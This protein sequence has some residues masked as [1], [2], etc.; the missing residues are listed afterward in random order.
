MASLSDKAKIW[1]RLVSEGQ[2]CH[3]AT[4][5]LRAPIS[6]CRQPSRTIVRRASIRKPEMKTA[7]GVFIVE[8]AFAATQDCAGLRPGT[9]INRQFPCIMMF[10]AHLT[11]ACPN[12]QPPGDIPQIS[13]IFEFL[14]SAVEC[15]IIWDCLLSQPDTSMQCGFMRPSGKKILHVLATDGTAVRGTI[16]CTHEG[17]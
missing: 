17:V 5:T 7:G 6:R 16:P 11:C 2:N 3:A 14:V 4:I 8:C 15:P 9:C 12:T 13:I 10:A 1:S